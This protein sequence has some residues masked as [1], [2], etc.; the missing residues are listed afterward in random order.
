MIG[1][2]SDLK[3]I[4]TDTRAGMEQ[5]NA[6]LDRVVALLEQLVEIQ[7]DEVRRAS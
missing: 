5:I 4:V 7:L 6:N 1:I 3:D 2:P